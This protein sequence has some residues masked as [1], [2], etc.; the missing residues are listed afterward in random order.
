[1]WELIN[2][3]DMFVFLFCCI[4][5]QAMLAAQRHDDHPRSSSNMGHH[6]LGNSLGSG[7]SDS[8]CHD[9]V[10]DDE[11]VDVVGNDHRPDSVSPPPVRHHGEYKI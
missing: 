1:M 4:C 5:R 7:P 11:R 8:M 3:N 10:D 9:V 2:A 6:S